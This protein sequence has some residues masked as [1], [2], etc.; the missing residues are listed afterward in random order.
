[1][2]L[3]KYQKVVKVV[4]DEL[5]KVHPA[6]LDKLRTPH[7]KVSEADVSYRVLSH[8][9]SEGLLTPLDGKRNVSRLDLAWL[10][11]LRELRAFGMP[12]QS[13]RTLHDNLFI[14]VTTKE[15]S[16]IPEIKQLMKGVFGSSLQSLM[17]DVHFSG[18]ITLNLF[19]KYYVL[20]QSQSFNVYLY[21][22]ANGHFVP[23]IDSVQSKLETLEA[24]REITHDH[25]LVLRLDRL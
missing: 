17:G 10:N 16:Q 15:I 2:L 12:I 24:Y 23:H 19:E 18:N 4:L 5:P 6:T 11:V 9:R 8:W 1:M 13:L 7:F 20:Q 14:Q 22:A 21:I 25:H 3:P